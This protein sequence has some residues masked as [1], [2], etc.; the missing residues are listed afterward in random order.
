MVDEDLIFS[1]TKSKYLAQ[2]REEE[3]ITELLSI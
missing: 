3:G 2:S 1:W